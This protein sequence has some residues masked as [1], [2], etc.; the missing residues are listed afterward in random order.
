MDVLDN[1][2]IPSQDHIQVILA[3]KVTFKETMKQ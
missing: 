2:D 3:S 1:G